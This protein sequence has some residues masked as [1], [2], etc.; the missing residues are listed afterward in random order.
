HLARIEGMPLPERPRRRPA[1]IRI[2]EEPGQG[3]RR[4][5]LDQARRAV[6]PIHEQPE[7][8]GLLFWHALDTVPWEMH[9]RREL[10]D[11]PRGLVEESAGFLGLPE[12]LQEEDHP[13]DGPTRSAAAPAPAWPRRL[14]DERSPTVSKANLDEVPDPLDVLEGVHA[15]YPSH[16]GDVVLD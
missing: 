2:A 15:V 14:L 13:L 1:R 3:P 16:Q 8:R 7:R 12:R 10:A 4:A 6:E 11:P 9:V 5:L